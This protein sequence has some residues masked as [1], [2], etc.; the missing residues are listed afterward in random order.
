MESRYQA[1]VEY[2]FQQ[3][4]MFQRT[5]EM[6]HKMD[7]HKTIDL[8]AKLGD[9]HLKIKT[10]H[11]G[12][13]NGK[14]SVSH[15]LASVFQSAGLKVGLFTSPHYKDFRER[16][17]INGQFID[18]EFVIAFTEKTKAWYDALKPSFFELTSAMAFDYF[19]QQKVDLAIIEV[20]MGGRLDSTN[21]VEPLLSV[22]TNISYDHMEYLGDTL[23]KIASEKAG[24]IKAKTPVVIGEYHDETAEVFVNQSALKASPIVFASKNY[25]ILTIYSTAEFTHYDVYYKGKCIYFNIAVNLTGDYQVKNI[26]TA[27]EAIAQYNE[28]NEAVRITEAQIREGFKN[29]RSLTTFMGRWQVIQTSP[30]VIADSAHNLSGIELV[31][32]QL[33]NMRY[34]ELHIVFGTVKD[35]D[36]VSL[37]ELLPRR[38]QYYFAKANIPRGMESEQLKATA[39]EFHLKGEAY[40]SV[41]SAF[42]S[43]KAAAQKDD[44]IF[45]LGS[46]FVVA[47]VLP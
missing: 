42:E 19:A 41:Q 1:T 45:V 2:L 21:V 35:K 47:E 34:R 3:L 16:I 13:T 8:C 37:L 22:I 17:K 14:G 15:L 20:G 46:I 33:R 31:L 32:L 39:S 18:K 25:Q 36:P 4:P 7:L 9:P 24:I 30:L 29:L 28:L 6:V 44:L 38:A 43:A 27:L 11:V 26:A 23:P 10:I 12:G 40:A 5:G